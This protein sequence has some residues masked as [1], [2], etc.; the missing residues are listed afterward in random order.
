[1]A[2]L[3]WLTW[4]YL[5]GAWW[6]RSTSRIRQHYLRAHRCSGL[7]FAW[8][9]AGLLSTVALAGFWIVL[10]QL[11][12]IRGNPVGDFSEYP[13]IIVALVLG[14][15]SLIG[16]TTEEAGFRGYFQS[17][18]KKE[19]GAPLAI[20]TAAL[21]IAPGHGLS[22]GFAW[23]TVLFYL[24]VDVM[25]GTM[26]SLANSILPGI[27]VHFV[28]LVVFFT[29]V[30]PHDATRRFV[31]EDG[32]DPWFWIHVRSGALSL[33]RWRFW[34]LDPWRGSPKRALQ[35][36]LMRCLATFERAYFGGSSTRFE[37][38]RPT[39][40]GHRCSTRG[41]IDARPVRRVPN[42]PA[43]TSKVRARQSY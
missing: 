30:W 25:F 16:I 9:V 8:A 38:L 29:L 19:S 2:L 21:V 5:G 14:M 42:R 1:M 43:R 17:R 3:L 11:V 33:R 7:V 4:Q 34:L 10:F 18:W 40:A 22:Q 24:F 31:K 6:P 26:A 23:P 41:G 27:V 20:L 39:T 15:A 36:E 12:K 13:V 32:S 28:G 35:P 37:A